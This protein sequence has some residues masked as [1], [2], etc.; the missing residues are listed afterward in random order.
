M[1]IKYVLVNIASSWLFS[2]ASPCNVFVSNCR[3]EEFMHLK[4]V[5]KYLHA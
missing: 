5:L 1:I 2:I 3:I 4:A